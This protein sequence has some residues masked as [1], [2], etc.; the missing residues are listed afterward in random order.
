M[1]Q[2]IISAFADE[3]S[4]DLEAQIAALERNGI[5]P[6]EKEQYKYLAGRGI[7]NLVRGMLE[8]RGCYSEQL[9]ERHTI[10]SSLLMALGVDEE[11][12]TEDACRIE[13]CIS[14]QSFNAIKEIVSKSGK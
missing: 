10:L 12:A 8:F 9:Y 3:V 1:A 6:I 5:A 4:P 2:F 14:E 13:H 11:T 7:A